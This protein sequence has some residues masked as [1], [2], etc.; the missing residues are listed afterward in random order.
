MLT[1][2]QIVTT[3]A[4]ASYDHRTFRCRILE[5]CPFQNGHYYCVVAVKPMDGFDNG[6]RLA[7]LLESEVTA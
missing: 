7:T 3:T 5:V 1:V 2:G 4:E 6:S